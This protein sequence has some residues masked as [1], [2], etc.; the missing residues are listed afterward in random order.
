MSRGLRSADADIIVAV[1][2][3]S[4][5]TAQLMVTTVAASLAAPAFWPRFGGLRQV[6]LLDGQWQYG[7]NL[8]PRFDSMDPHFD[9]TPMGLTPNSTQVPSSM[10]A[11]LPGNLG[12]R[13]VSMYRRTFTQRGRARLQFL[14]CS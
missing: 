12:P 7:L 9:P 11:S 8:D 10:D 2:L 4:A 13:G 1:L 5:C 3:L 6:E 14:A